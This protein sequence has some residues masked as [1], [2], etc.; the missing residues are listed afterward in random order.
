MAWRASQMFAAYLIA[1]KNFPP[2]K[3]IEYAKAVNFGE[4]PVEGLLGKKLVIGFK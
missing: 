1:D 2:E 3:A 4:M